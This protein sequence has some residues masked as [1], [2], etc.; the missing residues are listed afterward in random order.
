MAQTVSQQPL[1]A[2]AWVCTEVNPVGFVV[3]KVALGQVFLQV[4]RFSLVNII[5]PWSSLFKKLKK[6]SSFVHSF[7]SSLI[8]IQG[9]TEGP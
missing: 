9:W 7:T 6:N 3:N 1:T 5:P 2:A 8:L 4:L